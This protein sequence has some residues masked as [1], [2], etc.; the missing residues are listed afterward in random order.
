MGGAQQ[1]RELQ[2]PGASSSQGVSRRISAVKC[3]ERA[4]T[5]T[6]PKCLSDLA[7]RRSSVT[8]AVAV[9]TVGEQ[10]AGAEGVEAGKAE[11]ALPQ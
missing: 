8:L 1:V 5:I 7:I 2:T 11:K 6:A 3:Q 4:T 9:G 10:E